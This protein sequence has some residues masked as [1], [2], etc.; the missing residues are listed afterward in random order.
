MRK[1]KDILFRCDDGVAIITLNRPGSLNALSARMA[2]ELCNVF[3]DVQSDDEVRAVVLHGAG[4]AFCAGGDVR[5]T[6]A[7]G[8]RTAEDISSVL[9]CFRRLTTAMYMLDRP[10]I[11]AADGVAYGA[12]FSLLLLSD[13]VLLSSRARLC[14][15]FQRI[16]LVPDC[17]AMFTLPR[18]V[19]VQ[20]AKELIFSAR[21]VRAEEALRLGLAMEITE[22]EQMM[23][24]AI[25]LAR[26]FCQASP[27][28]LRASKRGLNVALQSNLGATLALESASQAQALGSD[29]LRQAAENFSRKEPPLFRWPSSLPHGF[30]S[31]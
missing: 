17:G 18:W 29:Y 27:D 24:R 4:A 14:M 20:R 3:T 6:H 19:G 31:P 7:A 21:E 15:A 8:H 10:V 25:Q 23:P 11:A 28:A 1:F 9:E 2:T 16:G 5:A 30:P 22:P 13:I 26:A 12:G